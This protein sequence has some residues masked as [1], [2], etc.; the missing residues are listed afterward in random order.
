MIHKQL[1]NN[2]RHL[3]PPD[4][5]VAYGCVRSGL[6]SDALEPDHVLLSVAHHGNSFSGDDD[7][8]LCSG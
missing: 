3:C 6:L 5:G 1:C 4:F 7:P 8:Q 2:R